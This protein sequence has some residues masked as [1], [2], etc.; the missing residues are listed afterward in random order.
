MGTSTSPFG[1]GKRESHDATD[2]YARF[3]PPEISADG[4][5][6][7]FT[8]DP[9]LICGDARAMDELKP[10][11]VALVVTSPPYFAG[12]EYESA[13][14]AGHVPATYLDYLAMLRDVFEECKRVLEPGGRIAVNVANLGRR[15]YR[16]L[17]ADV[18]RILQDDLGLL[19]RGEIVWVKAEGASGSCAWGSF[20][21]AA[22]PVLRDVSERV[23]V[24]SKGRFDRA[25]KGESTMSTDEFLESTLDVWRLPTESAR[26]VGHPAPFP[27]DLP[28]RR[29]ELYTFRD[30]LVLDPF[31]GSGSTAVA[32][33]R[34]GRR[35]CGY[36]TD[37]AYVELA[38]TRVAAEA[39]RPDRPGLNAAAVAEGLLV[40][41]GFSVVDRDLRL[42]KLGLTVDLLVEG[43]DGRRWYVDV[44]GALTVGRAGLART[45][46]VWRVIGQASV[47]DRP[48]LLLTS[49]LPTAND[50]ALKAAGLDPIGLTS[51]D[52]PDRLRAYATG[53]EPSRPA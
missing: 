48:M 16:S 34:T 2:F 37:P 51:P 41:A 11:S 39:R 1:V 53:M 26:R 28:Q 7:D 12:K 49:H 38:R 24:A 40:A 35:Y 43:A 21:K 44:S 46:E 19:L 32:A 14:G 52:A 5:V 18:T 36:D 9:P 6:V 33:V 31:L 25:R 29:I 3:R 15:P 4:E 10:A 8:P 20:R 22:N 17:S 45:D 50:R 30:D 23:V 42:P 13:L 47:L 27:V